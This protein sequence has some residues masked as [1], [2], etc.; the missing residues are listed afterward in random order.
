MGRVVFF[1]GVDRCYVRNVSVMYGCVVLGKR[2]VKGGGMG[3][4]RKWERREIVL[5]SCRGVGGMVRCIW[6]KEV[7]NCSNGM[8]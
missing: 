7:Y 3:F 5:D 2:W 1:I 6:K 4:M 8:G